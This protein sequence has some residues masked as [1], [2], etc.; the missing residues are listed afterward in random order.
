L[1]SGEVWWQGDLGLDNSDVRLSYDVSLTLAHRL[2]LMTRKI[3]PTDGAR[4]GESSTHPAN[5]ST[6]PANCKVVP[7][8]VTHADFMADFLSRNGVAAAAVHSGPTS[9]PR[10]IGGAVARR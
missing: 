9:A 5:C 2:T 3:R 1:P 10:A 8:T 4:G 7:V 6:H